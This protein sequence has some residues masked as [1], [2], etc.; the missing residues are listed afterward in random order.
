MASECP[1]LHDGLEGVDRHL[2]AFALER[3]HDGIEP[4]NLFR[5]LDCSRTWVAGGCADI[6]GICAIAYELE[7]VSDRALGIGMT[8]AC[9]K[10]IL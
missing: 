5:R 7:R 8:A 3:G 9:E 2:N 6:D 10:R 4:A 1:A